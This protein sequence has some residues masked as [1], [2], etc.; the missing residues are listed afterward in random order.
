M[1]YWE[2]YSQEESLPG[3][4]PMSFYDT[5]PKR[6]ESVLDKIAAKPESYPEGLLIG[7][8]HRM[9]DLLGARIVVYLRT[10]LLLIDRA[11]RSDPRLEL[12]PEDP[13]IAYLPHP[14]VVSLG[15]DF[16]RN[17]TQEKPSG[18][19]S[20]HYIVRLTNPIAKSTPWFEIQVRTLAQHA[21]AEVEHALGYKPDVH[22]PRHV[23]RQLAIL[24]RQAATFDEEFD[25]L[26]D[27]LDAAAMRGDD[28]H[29]G[30]RISGQTLPGL[31]READLRIS[32]DWIGP[33]AKL[34]MARGVTTA[35]AF[36]RLMKAEVVAEDT[37][38]R[39]TAPDLI[40]AEYLRVE[41]RSPRDSEMIGALANLADLLESGKVQEAAAIG[42][43][44]A[45]IEYDRAWKVLRPGARRANVGFGEPVAHRVH[46]SS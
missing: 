41:R 26:R 10:D 16:P 12:C 46:R 34:L 17:R 4:S 33:V 44:R 22:V 23:E 13:P 32:R 3:P 2:E 20:V 38:Q 29:D 43:I 31:I 39:R 40:R 9:H 25:L 14:L 1:E 7:S 42:R 36:R 19:A 11:I 30:T 28:I 6:P 8:L 21:W 27:Q 37:G 24:A 15:L 5:R 18:Y 45:A 35:G